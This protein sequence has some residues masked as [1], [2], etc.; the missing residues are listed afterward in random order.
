[1]VPRPD[2]PHDVVDA[3]EFVSVDE[4]VRRLSRLDFGPMRDPVIAHLRGQGG[5]AGLW[6]WRMAVADDLQRPLAVIP[7]DLTDEQA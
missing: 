1:V 2:D 3:A 7:L 5:V 6:L 4:A